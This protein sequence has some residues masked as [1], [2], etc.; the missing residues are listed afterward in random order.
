MQSQTA[1][2]AGNNS[3]L[4]GPPRKTLLRN[5]HRGRE[6]GASWGLNRAVPGRGPKATQRVLKDD[7]GRWQEALWRS[8]GGRDV[9]GP[10]RDQNVEVVMKTSVTRLNRGEVQEERLDC[11][12]PCQTLLLKE[13]VE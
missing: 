3:S 4:E 5:H 8:G 11:L 9:K 13:A 6:S 2:P 10:E 12:S 7:P 1:S